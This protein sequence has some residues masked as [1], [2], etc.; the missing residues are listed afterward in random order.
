[1]TQMSQLCTEEM[2]MTPSRS[3]IQNFMWHFSKNTPKYKFATLSCNR[4]TLCNISRKKSHVTRATPTGTVDTVH[5]KT[6]IQVSYRSQGQEVWNAGW[7]SSLLKKEPARFF[8]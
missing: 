7:I 6:H 1:M 2:K 3:K 4:Q 8:Q 5:S